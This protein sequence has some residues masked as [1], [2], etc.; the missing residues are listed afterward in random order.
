MSSD[1]FIE[2]SNLRESGAQGVSPSRIGSGSRDRSR[3]YVVGKTVYP[4]TRGMSSRSQRGNLVEGALCTATRGVAAWL[5]RHPGLG[6]L[7]LENLGLDGRD[8]SRVMVEVTSVAEATRASPN[9][10]DAGLL[11]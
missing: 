8:P 6:R 9:H 7:N 4:P 5:G 11:G 2:D 1:K 3:A 10:A